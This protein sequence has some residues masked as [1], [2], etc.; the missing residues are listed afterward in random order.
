MKNGVLCCHLKSAP[1]KGK[2][3]KELVSFISQS[4]AIPQAQIVI[5]RGETIRFKR[6]VIDAPLSM[7]Q[8]LERVGIQEQLGLFDT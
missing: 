6:I 2:A 1:E 8:F 3:N 5:V 4:L 7:D